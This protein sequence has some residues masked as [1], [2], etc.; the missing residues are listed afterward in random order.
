MMRLLLVVL[1]VEAAAGGAP[2]GMVWDGQKGWVPEEAQQGGM[3][4]LGGEEDLLVRTAPQQAGLMEASELSVELE[5]ESMLE[6]NGLSEQEALEAAVVA[7]A[8][9]APLIGANGEDRSVPA[10]REDSGAGRRDDVR[11]PAQII[12]EEFVPSAAEFI[13]GAELMPDEEDPEARAVREETEAAMIAQQDA[14]DAAKAKIDRLHA[15]LAQGMAP[16]DMTAPPQGATSKM[17]RVTGGRTPVGDMDANRAALLGG[18]GGGGAAGDSA[19]GGGDSMDPDEARRIQEQVQAK[20][21]EVMLMREMARSRMRRG[22]NAGDDLSP[23]ERDHLRQQARAEERRQPGWEP[24]HGYGASAEERLAQAR[25]KRDRVAPPPLSEP[26]PPP[27]TAES[28]GGEGVWYQVDGGGAV[29]FRSKPEKNARTK[30]VAEAHTLVYAVPDPAAPKGWIKTATH[31][32]LPL[33]Y[34]IGPLGNRDGPS[35]AE[36]AEAHAAHAALAA[37]EGYVRAPVAPPPVAPPA[38]APEPSWAT[39]CVDSDWKCNLWAASGECE[40]DAAFM[41]TKCRLACGLCEPTESE[42]AG[43]A[44]G[45]AKLEDLY[46]KAKAELPPPPPPPPPLPP[47]E[48]AATAANEGAEANAAPAVSSVDHAS[49]PP[50]PQEGT[51]ACGVA[52]ANEVAAADVQ[53]PAA[54]PAPKLRTIRRSSSS[55]S[56]S[57]GAAA[58]GGTQRRTLSSRPTKLVTKSPTLKQ[59]LERTRQAVPKLETMAR[60]E[61]KGNGRAAPS[62]TSD[63]MNPSDLPSTLEDERAWLRAEKR[64]LQKEQDDVARALAEAGQPASMGM[65]IGSL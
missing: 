43:S 40:A 19:D 11:S 45:T 24:S 39:G 63:P 38:P 13:P 41:A 20:R 31:L 8:I 55:S 64:R 3:M 62:A 53:D 58:A 33:T 5:K 6:L 60:P 1:L 51:A 61:L 30:V 59:E 65:G 23:M 42:S 47:S 4:T 12:T 50:P 26:A 21:E 36:A 17:K 56:S 18:G 22:G 2:P 49:G 48:R 37:A 29:A 16:A 25:A 35:I 14:L 10:P 9:A 27:S 7:E 15:S 54:V 28:T 44:P 46:A 34:L 32:W 57:S 52:V